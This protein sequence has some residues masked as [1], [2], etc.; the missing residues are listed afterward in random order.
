MILPHEEK[1]GREKKSRPKGGGEEAEK[2]LD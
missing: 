1:E 2:T